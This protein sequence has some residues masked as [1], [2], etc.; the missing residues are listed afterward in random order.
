MGALL[1]GGIDSSTNV[2]PFSEGEGGPVSTFSIGFEGECA[3]CENELDF[4]RMMA[5]HVRLGDHE[6]SVARTPRGGPQIGVQS[7]VSTDSGAKDRLS[8]SATAP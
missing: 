3:P 6:L 2:S 7:P 5:E 1:S 4:A 8:L